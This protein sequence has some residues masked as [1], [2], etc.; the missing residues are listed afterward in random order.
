MS[1]IYLIEMVENFYT[2]WGYP[3]VFLSSLIETSPL[4]FTVPGGLIVAVGGFFAYTG[5]VSF[6]GILLAGTLGMQLT[7]IIAYYAG[8]KTGKKLIK[9]F[10]QE[11]NA[12]KAKQLLTNHGPV[13]LTTSLM[14]NLTRFWVAFIAGTQNYNF[15][16]FLFYAGAASLTWNSLLV[17]VGYL[18]GTEREQIESGLAKLGILAWILLVI[19]LVVIYW[20]NKKEFKLSK[21]E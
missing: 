17:T 18:A 16:K 14:A 6:V 7:F 5:K 1:T 21:G 2:V 4:G 20:A 19:A 11:K 15:P 13:I 10:K 3:F 12:K 9:R 8:K